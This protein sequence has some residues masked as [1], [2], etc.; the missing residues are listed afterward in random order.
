MSK[1]GSLNDKAFVS[2]VN[3]IFN[4]FFGDSRKA[5]DKSYLLFNGSIQFQ[6]VFSTFGVSIIG[7]DANLFVLDFSYWL[8]VDASESV[9]SLGMHLPYF[10]TF[11]KVGVLVI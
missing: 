1:T 2:F 9:S 4:V 8:S 7:I 5:F 10:G 11:V 3:M 6:F